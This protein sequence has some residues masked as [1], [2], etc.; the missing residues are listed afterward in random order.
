MERGPLE[1][2]LAARDYEGV[3]KAIADGADVNLPFADALTPL[4]R[5]A[6]LGE[7]R[8]LKVLLS[9]GANVDAVAGRDGSEPPTAVAGH[10]VEAGFAALHWASREG[11]LECASLLIQGCS[12]YS[13]YCS[14][15]L[16]RAQSA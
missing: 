15:I 1:L 8:I 2:A 11:K 9:A 7:R 3:R 4:C 13:K 14:L 16:D 6:A 5:A 10:V 12:S